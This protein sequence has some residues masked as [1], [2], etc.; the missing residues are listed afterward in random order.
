MHQ[1]ILRYFSRFIPLD[2]A[3]I[4]A[5]TASIPVRTY[6]KGAFLLKE[7]EIARTSYFNVQGCVRLYYLVDGVERTTFF[8]TENQFITS[9][10][11]F[12]RKL[13]SDHYLECIEDCTLALLHYEVERKLLQ[14]Y[15]KLE[16]L[17]RII[18]EEELG[19]YQEMLSDYILSSPEKRYRELIDKRPELI[20]RVPQYQLAS[21]LGV[22]PES[23]SRI[24]KRLGR[25]RFLT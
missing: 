20:E 25:N 22:Q 17:S 10:R 14:Q 5:L 21:Y 23:L 6:D 1:A 19:N 15:P 12:T 7:G 9:M 11:S 24:R 4:Q 18:L 3:E 8:Y 16:T 13:P 2:E